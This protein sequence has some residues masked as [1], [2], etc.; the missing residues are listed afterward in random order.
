MIFLATA[1]ALFVRLSPGQRAPRARFS[2]GYG[3]NLCKNDSAV[4]APAMGGVLEA[5]IQFL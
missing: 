5:Y 2:Y 3:Y 4:A 1:G